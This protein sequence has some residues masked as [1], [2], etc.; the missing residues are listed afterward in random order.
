MNATT[1]T[2][3][4]V[5]LPDDSAGDVTFSK[6]TITQANEVSHV[7]LAN[8][9][10]NN[11][12]TI[13]CF[14]EGSLVS[15]PRGARAVGT[16]EVGDLIDTYEFGPLPVVAVHRQHVDL[17]NP[18]IHMGAVPVAISANALGPNVPSRCLL[19][20]RQHRMLVFKGGAGFYVPAKDL[21]GLPGI[22]QDDMRSSVDYV[23]IALDRH[24]TI[25]AEGAPA[26]TMR[27]AG[28]GAAPYPLN[29][30]ETRGHKARTLLEQLYHDQGALVSA[31]PFERSQLAL[32]SGG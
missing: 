7:D 28:K 8:V 23:H 21:L 9:A 27:D 11:N 30:P 16:L 14:L 4:W 19:V 20:S 31:T 18:D 2:S 17:R 32:A 3:E 22:V 24:A 29:W 5:F 13:S 10:V 6:A 15:T 1:S 26:E 12:V 25:F